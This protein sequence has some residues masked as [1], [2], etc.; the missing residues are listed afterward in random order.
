MSL[1]GT[2][3]RNIREKRKKSQKSVATQM[4]IS[5]QYLSNV[6]RGQYAIAPKH[7]KAASKTLRVKSSTLVEL[8]VA[9]FKETLT[10]QLKT[11]AT[12]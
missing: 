4:G 3:L 1:L 9:D 12:K 11:R 2:E 6:E 7:I 8:A 5:A 10:K